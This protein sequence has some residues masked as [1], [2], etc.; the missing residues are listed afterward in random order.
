MTDNIPTAFTPNN[1]GL[2]DVFR[3]SGLKF[4]KLL[5]FRVFN[6]WGQVIFQTN[7]IEKGWDGTFNGHP[8]DMGTYVYEIT[9]AHPDGTRKT[10]KG[11]VTLIR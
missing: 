7:S 1:D 11:S 2:N 10:Y 8:Q 9:V 3:I 6:R 4:Q 5:D